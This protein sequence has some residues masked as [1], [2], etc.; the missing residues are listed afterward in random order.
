VVFCN[1]IYCSS[2]W[3]QIVPWEAWLPLIS[4][5]KRHHFSNVNSDIDCGEV[6]NIYLDDME[7]E[8][9][10]DVYSPEDIKIGDDEYVPEPAAEHALAQVISDE[11]EGNDSDS[12]C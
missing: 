6:G 3:L 9:D 8:E 5:K 2:F 11:D 10:D 1:S 12:V 4:S 7:D